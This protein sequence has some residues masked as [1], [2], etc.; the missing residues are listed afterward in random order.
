MKKPV[1]FK[2]EL[3]ISE[4]PYY[5][6]KGK[7]KWAKLT[8]EQKLEIRLELNYFKLSE[9]Q[10]HPKS[11]Q[12]NQYYMFLPETLDRMMKKRKNDKLVKAISF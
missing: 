6:R 9:M 4:A 11:L 3:D 10:V 7:Q 8:P 1:T 5:D 2:S 12:N